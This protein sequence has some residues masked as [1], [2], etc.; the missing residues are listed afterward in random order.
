MIVSCLNGGLGNQM[1]QYAAAR[2]LADASGEN[3]TLDIRDLKAPLLPRKNRGI[4]R[5]YRL[6]V[7][8]PRAVLAGRWDL[9]SRGFLVSRKARLFLAKKGWIRGE[10][11]LEKDFTYQPLSAAPGRFT[12]LEGYWQS[13]RY[14]EPN[15]ENILADFTL[16][17]EAAGKN[18]E[19]LEK[20]RSQNSVC[21]HVRLGDYVNFASASAAHG[22]LTA[23]YYRAALRRLGSVGPRKSFYLFSDE[24]E[25]AVRLLGKGLKITVVDHNTQTPQEDLRLMSACRYFVTANS[26]FS[27]WAAWLSQR[28]GKRVFSP[29]K[30]FAGLA[31]DTRDLVPKGWI[32]L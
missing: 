14:F 30:W 24:P 27:W 4:F 25:K 16:D 19:I 5:P 18:L 10:Y 13:W 2:S 11:V 12:Y 8:R 20:I 21:L 23:D 3:L 31:H 17:T 32:R 28:P 7:F 1:F 6:D 22:N 29:K 9:D 15:R 26:S